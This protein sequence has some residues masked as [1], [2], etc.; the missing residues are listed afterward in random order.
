M[1]GPA[2]PEGDAKPGDDMGAKAATGDL[3]GY[4]GPNPTGPGRV[5]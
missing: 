4:K 2:T 1:A 5:E 3:G